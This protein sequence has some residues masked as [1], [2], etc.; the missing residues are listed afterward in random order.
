MLSQNNVRLVVS[1]LEAQIAELKEDLEKV[2]YKISKQAIQSTIN[3][4]EE[5]LKSNKIKLL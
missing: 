3:H 4:L 1:T 2:S 5:T